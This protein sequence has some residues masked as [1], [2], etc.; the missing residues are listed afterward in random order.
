MTIRE[1]FEAVCVNKS[2][3]RYMAEPV[4]RLVFQTPKGICSFRVSEPTFKNVR[5]SQKGKLVVEANRLVS[6]G[7]MEETHRPVSTDSSWL[8]LQA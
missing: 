7:S 1:S 3:N 5:I 2:A 8:R 4:Y 6:F